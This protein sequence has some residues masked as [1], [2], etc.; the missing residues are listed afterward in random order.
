MNN[1]SVIVSIIFIVKSCCSQG[2]VGQ[3]CLWW[4]SSHMRWGFSQLLQKAVGSFTQ[5][6]WLDC[7]KEMCRKLISHWNWQSE[8]A[9]A[10][11]QCQP[12]REFF[13]EV[14]ELEKCL[15]SGGWAG[16]RI[17]FRLQWPVSHL[18]GPCDL[19]SFIWKM[20]PHVILEKPVSCSSK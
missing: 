8:N 2:M 19:I 1:S 16:R 11:R 18:Y 15:Y 10:N 4:R 12:N 13:V 3:T 6:R 14:V 20:L 5:L 17:I 9:S 7:H